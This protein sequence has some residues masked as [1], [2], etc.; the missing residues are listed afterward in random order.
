[1]L[2]LIFLKV[3]S[4]VSSSPVVGCLRFAK[5]VA[6]NYF[7]CYPSSFLVP[8]QQC[9]EIIILHKI[10]NLRTNNDS[11][12]ECGFPEENKGKI[13]IMLAINVSFTVSFLKYHLAISF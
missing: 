4:T 2:H 13:F 12:F 7:K 9:I 8:S 11:L 10:P 1:M 3:A 5:R 6:N